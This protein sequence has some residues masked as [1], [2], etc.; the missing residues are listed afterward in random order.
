MSP[1]DGSSKGGGIEIAIAR[2]IE[3]PPEQV[4]DAWLDQGSVGRWLFATP[5]GVLKRVVVEPHVGGGFVISEERDG[6]VAEHVGTYLEID[7]PRRLA[8]EFA[9]DPNEKPVRVTVVFVPEAGAT[10]V[11]LRQ[12]V[13]AKWVEFADRG[14]AG[15][16]TILAGLARVVETAQSKVLNPQQKEPAMSINPYIFIRWQLRGGFQILRTRSRRQNSHDASACRNPGCRSRPQG[17][18][19]QNHSRAN[20]DRRCLSNGLRRTPR[21]FQ[22]APGLQRQHQRRYPG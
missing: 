10:N 17:L 5:G 14:R 15:W 6:Q 3:A 9:A 18:G 16:T 20:E 22:E 2:H 7:R 4:F 8:F 1:E 11:T 12:E 13:P 19:P 21:A